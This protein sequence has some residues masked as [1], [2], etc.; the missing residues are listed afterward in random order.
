MKET[1]D[2]VIR[3][4][5]EEM[6]NIQNKSK[7]FMQLLTH[8]EN[9][10]ENLVLLLLRLKLYRHMKVT[11]ISEAFMLTP[12]AGTNMCDKLEDLDYV[13]R[14]RTKDDR[15]VVRVSLTKKGEERVEGIF[16]KFS[17]E[18]LKRMSS[19]LAEINSLFEKIAE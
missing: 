8:D 3:R 4:L 9:L 13:E 5:M 16:S 1:S 18:K 11:E 10:S 7:E 15:R 6:F 17:E 19:V 2:D 12:G 14:I